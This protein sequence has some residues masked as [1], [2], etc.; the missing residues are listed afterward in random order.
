MK[1]VLSMHPLKPKP[2]HWERQHW[3]R[4]RSRLPWL[5]RVFLLFRLSPWT[6][7]C[8]RLGALWTAHRPRDSGRG[9][10]TRAPSRPVKGMGAGG[11][12]VSS[13]GLGQPQREWVGVEVHP[14]GS[15]APGCSWD[16]ELLRLTCPRTHVRQAHFRTFFLLLF[17][18]PEFS[19]G[20]A[21]PSPHTRL[22]GSSDTS[23]LSGSSLW[24]HCR[25]SGVCGGP[26]EVTVTAKNG[27][28][29]GRA[30]PRAGESRRKQP[31]LFLL[32][33]REL[34]TG[35]QPTVQVSVGAHTPGQARQPLLGR[36][37]LGGGEV[38]GRDTSDI[39]SPGPVISLWDDSKTVIL[40]VTADTLA[41]RGWGEVGGTHSSTPQ[42]FLPRTLVSSSRLDSALEG[43]RSLKEAKQMCLPREGCL[44][45]VI[46]GCSGEEVRRGDQARAEAE[47]GSPRPLTHQP[48]SSPEASLSPSPSPGPRVPGVPPSTH[49]SSQPHSAQPPGARRSNCRAP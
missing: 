20:Q 12:E 6:L 11:G 4:L 36:G 22:P 2:S 9:E 25:L 39:L 28:I 38:P 26:T 18:L 14:T 29:T 24:A 15:G 10:E 43:P 44:P 42:R 30:T 16:P 21:P 5:P 3:R 45:Q 37:L 23:H 32:L 7:S 33:L 27:L 13:T 41:A 46:S 48:N 31:L 8:H 47:M 40:R 35:Q 19:L 34:I 17:L 1:K 49:F